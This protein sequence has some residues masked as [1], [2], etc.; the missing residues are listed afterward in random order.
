MQP[1]G[2]VDT[3]V[4]TDKGR[5]AVD[6]QGLHRRERTVNGDNHET[7]CVP[8]STTNGDNYETLWVL[9]NRQPIMNATGSEKQREGSRR[10]VS[11]HNAGALSHREHDI[12]GREDG[13]FEPSHAPEDLPVALVTI[14]RGNVVKHPGLAA[15]HESCDVVHP[16]TTYEPVGSNDDNSGDDTPGSPDGISITPGSSCSTCKSSSNSVAEGGTGAFSSEHIE[17][18]DTLTTS[19]LSMTYNKNDKPLFISP[20]HDDRVQYY[21]H[22]GTMDFLARQELEQLATER[23]RED[24][25]RAEEERRRDLAS[26]GQ[27]MNRT[28]RKMLARGGRV[29]KPQGRKANSGS[30]QSVFER[31]ASPTRVEDTIPAAETGAPG[32]GYP[33]KDLVLRSQLGGCARQPFQPTISRRSNLLASRKTDRSDESRLCERLHKEWDGT[34]GKR[35]RRVERADQAL[36]DKAAASYVRP[37][38]ERILARRFRFTMTKALSVSNS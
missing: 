34:Q 33:H 36:R 15:R 14:A 26:S 19:A 8:E 32:S 5:D 7:L 20:V 11:M 10:R 16:A 4:G 23:K 18:P 17:E 2:S 29:G 24:R 21:E 28:S 27:W 25:Q 38:S 1:T 22:Y 35:E 13:G 37:V 31:L 12:D 9:D 30:R 3:E 6:G